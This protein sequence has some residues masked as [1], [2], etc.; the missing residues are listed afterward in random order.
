MAFPLLFQFPGKVTVLKK[1]TGRLPILLDIEKGH[2]VQQSDTALLV[3]A[4]IGQKGDGQ[5]AAAGRQALVSLKRFAELFRQHGKSFFP[6]QPGMAPGGKF[7]GRQTVFQ[8]LLRCERLPGV[9]DQQAV[10]Q[11]ELDGRPGDPPRAGIIGFRREQ[12][13]AAPDDR[14]QTGKTLRIVFQQA[15]H[16]EAPDE[17]ADP[18][19]ENGGDAEQ[20]E[21][22]RKGP[23][24]P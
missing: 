10:F 6:I 20:N 1:R 2:R 8:S 9:I 14:P 17:S 5:S 4:R 13:L 18:A 22:Q 16:I 19:H 15:F 21:Q 3:S 11:R 23:A 7:R 24:N 12:I